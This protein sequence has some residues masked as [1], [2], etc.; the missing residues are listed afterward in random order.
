M[1]RMKSYFSSSSP[2]LFFAYALINFVRICFQAERFN[3]ACG[4]SESHSVLLDVC[5]KG[6]IV[7][8]VYGSGSN[9][10]QTACRLFITSPA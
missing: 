8:H 10:D 9:L 4:F 6:L 1:H 3:I 2:G 7:S 5:Q